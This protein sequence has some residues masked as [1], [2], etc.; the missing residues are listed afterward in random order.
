M[1][2]H[3]NSGNSTYQIQSINSHSVT[4]NEKVYS[5]S[6]IVMPESLHKWNVENFETLNIT[7]F[8]QLCALQPEVVL[9]GTGQKIRFPTSDLLAPLINEGEGRKV[10]AGLLINNKG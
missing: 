9:L 5:H 2:L 7:H 1:K 10:A 4:I 8:Q 6:L 3:L